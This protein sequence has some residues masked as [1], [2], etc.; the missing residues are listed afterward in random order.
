MSFYVCLCGTRSINYLSNVHG[1]LFVTGKLHRNLRLNVEHIPDS[2]LGDIEE[3]DGESREA[4]NSSHDGF[5][6]DDTDLEPI[7]ECIHTHTR[8]LQPISIKYG[9][10]KLLWIFLT[11]H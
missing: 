9:F 1:I 6:S 4:L 2:N 11:N 10:L 5:R 8:D 3:E 7:S